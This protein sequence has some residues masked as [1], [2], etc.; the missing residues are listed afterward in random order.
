MKE[1][2]VHLTKYMGAE[3]GP[4]VATAATADEAIAA[5]KNYIAEHDKRAGPDNWNY[6]RFGGVLSD[7]GVCIDYGSYSTFFYIEGISFAE[8]L[9]SQSKKE[10]GEK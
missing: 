5:V 2:K 8:M 10:N 1:L 4:V 3:D 6:W 9:N 7:E